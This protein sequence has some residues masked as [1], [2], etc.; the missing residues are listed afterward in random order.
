MP[1]QII[2]GRHGGDAMS[3]HQPSVQQNCTY[4]VTNNGG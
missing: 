3:H 2:E 4:L 1:P